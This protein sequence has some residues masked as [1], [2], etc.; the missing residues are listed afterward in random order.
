MAGNRKGTIA[1]VTGAV[2]DA[3][4]S[5]AHAAGEHVIEPVGK[6]LGLTGTKKAGKPK[7]RKGAAVRMMT[8]AVAGKTPARPGGKG[9]GAQAGARPSQKPAA[10]RGGKG[11]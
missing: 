1:K 3:A 9:R 8:N 10:G 11:R 7:A 6:A 4:A 2:H 5:V